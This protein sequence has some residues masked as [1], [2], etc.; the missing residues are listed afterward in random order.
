M[1]RWTRSPDE[2]RSKR[3]TEYD[4]TFREKLNLKLG[5]WT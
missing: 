4:A 5:G 2:A 1:P 3:I